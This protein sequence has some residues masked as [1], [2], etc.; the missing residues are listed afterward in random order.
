F[1]NPGFSL[2]RSLRKINSMQSSLIPTTTLR[3]HASAHKLRVLCITILECFRSL[4]KLCGSGSSLIYHS[5]KV[6]IS[7]KG[8]KFKTDNPQEVA[9]REEN[10]PLNYLRPCVL[11]D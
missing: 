5:S 7:K 11:C 3:V 8:T 2:A 1:K 6:F 4:R 9:Y 10:L